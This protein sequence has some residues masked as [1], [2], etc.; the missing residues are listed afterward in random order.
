MQTAV[1]SIISPNY[2]HYARVLM[3]SVQRHHPD[4]DRFVLVVGDGDAGDESFT[5]VP[6]SALPLPNPRQF[7][8]RYSL[9]ELN[10]A[11][12]PWMFEHLFA[13]GYDRV[14]Y[15]DPDIYLYSALAEVEASDA[16]ITLTPHLTGS[17][18]GDD[19]PSERTIL[20]AGTYNLGFL[21][22]TR[23]P[24]LERFLAWW[25]KRLELQCLVDT[26]RGLFVD[27][28]WMDLA[29]GFFPGVAILRHEGYNVAYW[30]LGQRTVAG[31]TV[32]GQPLRFFH[33]SGFDPAVPEMIS[34]HAGLQ[35]RDTGDARKLI[36][37]YAAALRA[38]GYES[39]K[40]APY[41]FGAFADGT[42][43]ASAARI[44][45]RNS[46]DLQAACGADPFARS[47][48]FNGIRDPST[49]VSLAAR[50][51]VASYRMLSRARPLVRLIP[52]SLRTSA[53]ELLLG[54]REAA[55]SD[56]SLQTGLNVVGYFERETGIGESARLCR[57]ACEA[58]R[59]PSHAIDVDRTGGISQQAIYPVSVFHVNADQ[60]PD[61]HKRMANVF[62][63]SAYN[64][65]VWHWELPESPDAW[66]SSAE[67]LDEIWAP[68]AFIQSAISRKVTI[69]VVHMPHGIEV[70]EIEAC[71]PEELGVPRGRFT[72]LTMFDFG[73]VVERKNP[74]GAVEALRRAESSAV[75]LIKTSGAD[76][77]PNEYAELEKRLRGIPNIYLVDRLL[78]RA[79]VNGLLAACDAVVSLH[80]SEGF[81]LILAEAMFRGKPVIATG[82]S[83]NMD[84]MNSANSC[85]VSYELVTLDRTIREYRAGQQWAEPNIDHAA[86]LM[87][88][89]AEDEAFRTQIGERARDTIRSQFSPAVAGERY[90][91]RLDVLS[92][93]SIH[94]SRRN[95][96]RPGRPS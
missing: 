93:S 43:I 74:L 34:N 53:R 55:R 46:P 94:D 36:E 75:L 26:A 30:N 77:H 73:S 66:I 15:L 54:R 56:V 87:R 21:A 37:G 61:V 6:L 78:S 65:G 1:F 39:F 58:S 83:G 44:A 92:V 69:P 3:A 16:F 88:R 11:V 24:P 32:N 89:V 70:T 4:W 5:T 76:R 96:G 51:G 57:H 90:R 42:P 40:N 27:Q 10:T 33:F 14:I 25:K 59:L 20:L 64:I 23:Q 7:C 91:R 28:K 68:S 49:H 50:A 80:R 13:R 62:D 60:V 31:Q 2:R 72:F 63:A 45:Y 95:P 41:A 52:R 84:F 81:G 9:I 22:V 86:H 71:S 8:F 85:P 18:N 35:V 29:P 38:A 19:H 47:E 82:W 67:P 12:K 48:I 79:R 17:I